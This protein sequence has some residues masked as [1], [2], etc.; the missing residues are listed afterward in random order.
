M[1]L[2]LERW[3][4]FLNEGSEEQLETGSTLTPSRRGDFD[5]LAE[6]F[7]DYA[8]DVGGGERDLTTEEY[9]DFAREH[10]ITFL[11]AGYAR[12]VFRVPEGALKIE[13]GSPPFR[14]NRNEALLW[15][16]APA[17]VAK[18]LVPVLDH[19]HD[20]GWLLMSEVEVGGVVTPEARGVLDDCGLGDFIYNSSNVAKDGRLVDY[21]FI[22]SYSL[23]ADCRELGRKQRQGSRAARKRTP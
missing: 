2:L 16:Q 22:H 5:Y 1:K 18:Y 17:S 8:S 7:R 13:G 4:R 10:G 9:E 3:K 6:A 12:A 11:G 19:A 15:K 20:N 14:D 21:G 23:F